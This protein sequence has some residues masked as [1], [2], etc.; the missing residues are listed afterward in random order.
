MFM[1]SNLMHLVSAISPDATVLTNTDGPVVSECME[2]MARRAIAGVTTARTE[3]KVC[4]PRIEEWLCPPCVGD[5]SR[6]SFRNLPM[7]FERDA[8][9]NFAKM[10][11]WESHP[12][13]STGH[14]SNATYFYLN[15]Q[16]AAN[17]TG[18]SKGVKPPWSAGIP[19]PDQ[20]PL[21]TLK[22][23]CWDADRG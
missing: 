15:F 22:I 20:N 23:F 2:G 12:R 19:F 5:G 8:A 14:L 13:L 16:G 3:A 10:R 11:P 4:S 17:G 21:Q 7:V 1:P 9:L 6:M 18:S